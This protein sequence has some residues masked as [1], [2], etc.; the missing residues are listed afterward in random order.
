MKKTLTV[1]ISGQVF[2]IDEDAY[3]ILN[4]YLESIRQHFAKTQGGDEICSDIEARIS[5]MLREKVSDQKQVVTI[6]DI[7]QIIKTIGEPGE[8]GS[9]AFEEPKGTRQKTPGGPAPKRLYRDPEHA[10][11]GGVCSGL[12][13]YFHTDMV[14]F[15]LGFVVAAV[16]GVGAPVLIYIVL[17]I[18]VP[19]ARTAAERLEMKGEKVDLSN[20]GQSVREEIDKLKHKLNDFAEEARGTYKKKSEYYRSDLDRAGNALGRLL[21][22]F[23]RIILVFIGIILFIIGISL[24][25]GFMT[26]V[27][28]F[29]HHIFFFDTE[30]ITL[31]VA[32]LLNLITGGQTDSNVFIKTGLI[33][34]LGIPVIMI[35]WGGIKLIFGIRQTKFVGIMFFNLW[36][37]GLIICLYF[38]YKLSKSFRYSGNSGEIRTIEM[39]RDSLISMKVLEDERIAN[40]S[41]RGEIIEI[42]DIKMMIIPNG[43]VVFHGIPE[44]RIE[45]ASGNDIQLQT[46]KMAKGRTTG[47]ADK[48]AGMIL[49]NHT[50]ADNNL[51]ID[52]FFIIP[53]N[54]LWRVQQVKLILRVPAGT[55]LRLDQ[56]L[57]RVLEDGFNDQEDLSGKLWLMTDEGLTKTDRPVM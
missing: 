11:L 26:L 20:I 50:Y 25:L 44:I 57:D 19:E 5:E 33:L 54:D 30:I 21:E 45:K 22:V 42:E 17:W 3:K 7:G 6:E 14:W 34:L 43:K 27:L 53:E 48:R 51:V 40:L 38:G 36:I 29:G 24:V 13:A 41:L 46:I 16:I 8:F 32:Q 49:Y 18:V 39:P 35:L 37:I 2:H 28:G 31:P 10:M 12:A 56:N 15:R 52:P 4:D 47:E 9:D 55:Y 23:I 1:N